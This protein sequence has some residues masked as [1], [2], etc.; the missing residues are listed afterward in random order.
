MGSLLANTGQLEKLTVEIHP[1]NAND[2]KDCKEYEPTFIQKLIRRCKHLK[3]K[4]DVKY[5]DENVPSSSMQCAEE[6]RG[7][8]G[9]VEEPINEKLHPDE[10]IAKLRPL[11]NFVA[12]VLNPRPVVKIA[13]LDDGAKLN[14]LDGKQKGMSFRPD[15]V[16]WWVGPC[17]HGTEMAHCIRKICPGAELYIARLDDS[18]KNE[19]EK[20]TIKSALEALKWALA[21]DVDIISISW[22]FKKAVEGEKD[23][24]EKEFTKLV[25]SLLG[26][27]ESH[28]WFSSR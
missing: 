6:E 13:L 11:Q 26:S 4:I 9:V 2:M 22:S 19:P 14:H 24:Y 17:S 23:E 3:Y 16:Q 1:K 27:K 28:V 25:E 10:W 20:F 15:N 8:K 12:N 21:W 18:R 7:R 5:P